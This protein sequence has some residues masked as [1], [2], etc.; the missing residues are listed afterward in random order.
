M[1]RLPDTLCT[2]SPRRFLLILVTTVP[3]LCG[4]AGATDW[5][6]DKA[7]SS[8]GFSVSHLVISDVT[9]TFRDFSA[10]VTTEDEDFSTARVHVVVQTGSIYTE[11]DKRD[12]HLR[13]DDFFGSEKFPEASF[14]STGV[15]KVGGTDYIVRGNLTIRDSTR[16]VDLKAKLNGIINDPRGNR[17]AGFKITGQVDRFGFG[18]KW[19]AATETG[20]LIAGERV[21]LTINL[22]LVA[23]KPKE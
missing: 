21:T 11:N 7:H 16:A 1:R 3:L 5:K 8:F 15:V 2:G 20:S 6:V 18:L 14:T 17:R 12:A 10:E 19:N 22:E 4:A 13:S 23:Q 9:G